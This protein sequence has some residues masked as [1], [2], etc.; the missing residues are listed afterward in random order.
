MSAWVSVPIYS[1]VSE[2]LRAQPMASALPRGDGGGI[3]TE[4]GGGGTRELSGTGRH[5]GGDDGGT[6]SGGGGKKR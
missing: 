3:I 2:R 6:K 5:S 1:G 4:I